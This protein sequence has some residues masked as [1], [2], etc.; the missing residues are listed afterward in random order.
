MPMLIVLAE[1]KRKYDDLSKNKQNNTVKANLLASYTEPIVTGNHTRDR[2]GATTQQHRNNNSNKTTVTITN[3]NR[4][5][6]NIN[7]KGNG[8]FECGDQGQFKRNCP[9]LRN[10]DRG[11]QDEMIRAPGKG[12]LQTRTSGVSKL[13]WYLCAAPVE[14]ATLAFLAAYEMKNLSEQLMYDG[15]SGY[16]PFDYREL[17]KLTVKNRYPSK[18]FDDLFDKLQGFSVYSKSTCKFGLTNAHAVFYRPHENDHGIYV[19]PTKIESIIEWTSPKSP[20]ETSVQFLVQQSLALPEESE[21]FHS[22]YC[23]ASKKGL[24]AVLMQ[25]ENVISYASRQLK[26]HEKNYTTHDLELG[27]VVFALKI[28]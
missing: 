27:A 25:R 10:N 2:Y 1:R 8:A 18:E 3:N 5:S 22:Q 15:S 4:N 26:I 20:T 17:N 7:Q 19:D 23:D 28:W 14:R 13:I 9:R 12:L 24:G 16:V 6:N 11:N 21:I